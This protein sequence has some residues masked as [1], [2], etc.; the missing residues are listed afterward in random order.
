[1]DIDPFSEQAIRQANPAFGDFQN[2]SEVLAMAA[3]AKRMP[4]SEAGYRN[5][6]LNQRV[7]A[8]TRFIAPSVWNACG[9]QP[10]PFDEDTPVY[11]G[12]DLSAANDL[13][14]CVMIG[15][16]DGVWQVHPTFWLPADGLPERSKS[17]RV[18]YDMWA[19]Q[20]FLQTV[21]G[22]TIEYEYVAKWL[23]EQFD[24][25]NIVKIGF[26]RWNFSNLKSSLLRN[27]FDELK[28]TQHFEEFGQG[29]QS[30]SPAL[31]ELEVVIL[32][33]NMAHGNHPV[34]SMCADAAVVLT[35]PQNNR[36]L[37]KQKS[38][39]RID[40]MVALTMAFGVA[41]TE[42]VKEPV[43]EMFVLS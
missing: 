32:N 29:F 23:R 31:R 18:P 27:D 16:V 24:L 13:T 12:L 42:E 30:M 11:A 19:K 43:F 6:V 37:S 7:A 26:D 17:D 15:K 10:E 5:L 34:L 40:G 33:A 9:N 21:P 35:D 41:N 14:A 39:R 36:K 28:I 3:N 8:S 2:A 20:G 25:Y 4:A 22:S 1:M 38:T